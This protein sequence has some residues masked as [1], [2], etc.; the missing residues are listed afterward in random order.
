MEV[1]KDFVVHAAGYNTTVLR[2]K[3]QS[4]Q[5]VVLGGLVLPAQ[6]VRGVIFNLGGIWTK[7]R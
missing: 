6:A 1:V 2:G 4:L 3:V 7:Y 5:T